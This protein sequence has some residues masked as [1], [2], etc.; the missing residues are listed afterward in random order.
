MSDINPAALSAMWGARAL[1]APDTLTPQLSEPPQGNSTQNFLDQKNYGAD[2]FAKAAME[3]VTTNDIDSQLVN[4][5]Q[6]RMDSYVDIVKYNKANGIPVKPAEI[7]GM[8]NQL[9]TS[10]SAKAD[11]LNSEKTAR[12]TKAATDAQQEYAALSSSYIT[13]RRQQM[14]L[15]QQMQA[16]ASKP[17]PD[18]NTITLLA[19]QKDVLDTE[20]NTMKKQFAKSGIDQPDAI[21]RDNQDT[22]GAWQ[23]TADQLLYKT[24]LGTYHDATG[25]FNDKAFLQDTQT[26]PEFQWLSPAE[27]WQKLIQQDND[28][29]TLWDIF[30]IAS[31]FADPT[32]LIQTLKSKWT[33]TDQQIAEAILLGYARN[34]NLHVDT[35]G[36]ESDP[37]AQQ[38]RATLQKTLR[39]AG[40][41]WSIITSIL[42][43]NWL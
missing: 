3:K 29:A 43:N 19:K 5:A 24:A 35:N 14:W 7:M 8:V 18:T 17:Q 34:N 42:D 13:A 41:K 16:E 31:Q 38:W 32:A 30:H 40:I 1:S 9:D 39:K 22:I 15:D 26:V 6:K 36:T 25:K 12:I 28:P 23:Q 2:I 10:L 4:L 27:I 33:M 37:Q 21:I 20:V 11:Q